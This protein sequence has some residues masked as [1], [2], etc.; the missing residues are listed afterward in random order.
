[1]RCLAFEPSRPP[2]PTTCQRGEMARRRHFH[3][4][5]GGLL[6]SLLAAIRRGGSP[7][8]PAR[9]IAEVAALRRS[10]RVVGIGA[11]ESTQYGGAGARSMT[12]VDEWDHGQLPEA[13]RTVHDD[14]ADD[15][16]ESAVRRVCG[17]A[18]KQTALSHGGVVLQAECLPRHAAGH[19]RR[20]TCLGT[21]RLRPSRCRASTLS[22]DEQISFTAPSHPLGSLPLQQL[23]STARC[24]GR[25]PERTTQWASTT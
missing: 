25:S 7:P 13:S 3:E 22:Q 21:M 15:D 19:H 10:L 4:H 8:A 24:D 1:M 9:Y 12:H 11:R 20:R 16:R 17:V 23:V 6:R 14:I 18:A 2:L 5:P